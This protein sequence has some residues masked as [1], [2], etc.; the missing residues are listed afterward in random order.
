MMRS[1]RSSF[2]TPEA[3]IAFQNTNAALVL[4]TLHL[5]GVPFFDRLSLIDF[6]D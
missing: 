4:C 2:G 1:S 3:R 5:C 6:P